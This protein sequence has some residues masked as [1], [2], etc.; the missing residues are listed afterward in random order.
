[1]ILEIESI[2]LSLCEIEE[3]LEAIADGAKEFLPH[4]GATDAPKLCK[5]LRIALR[6]LQAREIR[7]IAAT[8]E[9]P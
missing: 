3:R 8:L 2:N 4:V 7:E 6:Y 1:M 5:A 9:T